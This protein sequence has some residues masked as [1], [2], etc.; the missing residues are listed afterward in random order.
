MVKKTLPSNSTKVGDVESR[1][2]SK[3]RDTKHGKGKK[4]P[5]TQPKRERVSIK[6]NYI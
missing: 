6:V 4:N 3:P 5:K 1:R 2:D